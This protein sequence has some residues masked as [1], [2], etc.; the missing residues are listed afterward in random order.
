L[1][2]YRSRRYEALSRYRELLR[3]KEG[4][5]EVDDIVLL[6][7]LQAIALGCDTRLLLQKHAPTPAPTY[8]RTPPIGRTRSS[9]CAASFRRRFSTADQEKKI[10]ER[11]QPSP[12]KA[13]NV[14]H[15]RRSHLFGH[16]GFGYCGTRHG[17][18]GAVGEL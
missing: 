12:P 4:E 16:C 5:E 15:R 6:S 13:H 9:G 11:A 7:F 14:E 17:R 3:G 1:F 2:R 8:K 10:E 18:D